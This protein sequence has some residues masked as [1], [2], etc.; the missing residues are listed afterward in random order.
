MVNDCKRVEKLVHV[1]PH[2]L[3]RCFFFNHEKKK[4][5]W[6]FDRNLAGG[7][8][9]ILLDTRSINLST[10]F[11]VELFSEAIHSIVKILHIFMD[12]PLVFF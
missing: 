3:V 11:F 10:R 2:K 1:G 6:D 7:V 9:P 4:T 8:Q 5:F 12:F